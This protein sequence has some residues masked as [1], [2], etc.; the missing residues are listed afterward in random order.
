MLDSTLFLDQQ[1][2]SSTDKDLVLQGSI[3]SSDRIQSEF[4]LPSFVSGSIVL[5]LDEST[6]FDQINKSRPDM[7]R[8]ITNKEKG[9]RRSIISGSQ[10]NDRNQVIIKHIGLHA[11]TRSH[12]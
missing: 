12:V 1:P 10:Q 3:I 2:K 11:L 6:V 8:R 9:K 7:K 4:D 5:P